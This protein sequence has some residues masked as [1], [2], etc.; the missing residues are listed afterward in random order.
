M[1]HLKLSAEEKTGNTPIAENK[2]SPEYPPGLQIHL[3]ENELNKLG[4]KNLPEP[5]TRLSAATKMVTTG[6]MMHDGPDGQHKSL[7]LKITHMA[8]GGEK[9][10]HE[11]TD[12]DTKGKKLYGGEKEK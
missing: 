12:G 6:A 9:E 10:G 7:H 4:I 2:D 8:I 11:Q 3:T 5:G 1:K